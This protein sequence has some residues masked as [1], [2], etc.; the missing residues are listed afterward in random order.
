MHIKTGYHLLGESVCVCSIYSICTCV[1]DYLRVRV[2]IENE[3]K[4]CRINRKWNRKRK[5]NKNK[6]IFN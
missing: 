4:K 6:W 5:K 2:K 1:K 3:M